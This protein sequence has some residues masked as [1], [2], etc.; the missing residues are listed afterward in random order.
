MIA[1]WF[2]VQTEPQRETVATQLLERAGFQPYL[3]RIRLPNSQRITSLFPGYLFVSQADHWYSIKNTIGVRGI[4][5]SGP[6]PAKLPARIVE[7]I[8]SRE[9]GGLVRLPPPPRFRNGQPVGIIRGLFKGRI[10]IYVG[11][12]A[13]DRER[14]LIEALGRAITIDLPTSDLSPPHHA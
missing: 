3:P 10:G 2:V 9:R 13:R 1:A 12:G 14:V 8:R 5:M 7:D 11:M 6:T 4:L